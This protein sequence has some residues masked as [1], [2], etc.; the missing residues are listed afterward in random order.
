MLTWEIRKAPQTQEETQKHKSRKVEKCFWVKQSEKMSKVPGV[1]TSIETHLFT[2]INWTFV[3]VYFWH[4][5]GHWGDSGEQNKI[6]AH[7]ELFP[8]WGRYIGKLYNA[9]DIFKL[10]K[11]WRAGVIEGIQRNFSDMITLEQKLKVKDK[12]LF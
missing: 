11:Y 12:C 8:S 2:N 5:E 6:F 1:Q 10:Y 4:F 9:W 3:L 7:T